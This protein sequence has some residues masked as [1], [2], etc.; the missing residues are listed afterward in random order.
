MFNPFTVLVLMLL[1]TPSTKCVMTISRSVRIPDNTSDDD[2][3]A[4]A[5]SGLE[6]L[7]RNLQRIKDIIYSSLLVAM[8]GLTALSSLLLGALITIG[9]YDLAL[10]VSLCAFAAVLPLLAASYWNLKIWYGIPIPAPSVEIIR[11]EG[12]SREIKE[13]HFSAKLSYMQLLIFVPATFI[14]F[15]GVAGALWHM[16]WIATVVFAVAVILGCGFI[17][18]LSIQSIR[19]S[20]GRIFSDLADLFR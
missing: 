18:A 7:R 12:S 16:F 20:S 10:Q 19:Q 8:G 5:Q 6:Q 11:H 1:T 17:G 14:T 2:S 4:L 9:S 15:I 3:L 13:A